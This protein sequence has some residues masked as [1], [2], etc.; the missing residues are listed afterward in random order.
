V[1]DGDVGAQVEDLLGELL[2]QSGHQAA[3]TGEKIV[4]LLV[5]YYGSGLERICDIV[6]TDRPDLIYQ[7]AADP[8]VESQLILH[9]LHPLTVEGRI[10]AALDRVRPYLGSHAGGVSFLGIDD[11]GVARLKL[12]GSCHGCASSTVTVS[13]TIEEAV[14]AA[15]PELTSIEVDGEVPAS[16]VLQIG[17]RSDRPSAAAG[18]VWR[19][20]SAAELPREGHVTS[21]QLGSS[22]IVAVRVE[23][24]YYAYVDRCPAC[25][26]SLVNATLRGSVLTCPECDERYDVRLAGRAVDGS[27]RHLDPLPL[28][29][30]ASG[31]RVALPEAV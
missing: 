3:H 12:S 20:P 16:P 22:H 15:A 2:E 25:E 18:P 31:V 1:P 14:R 7:L 10:E 23:D 29:D 4:R 24:T 9:G 5:E 27:G 19:H 21:V 11:E 17:R 13:L 8:L 30:D 28:L 26:A 6:G